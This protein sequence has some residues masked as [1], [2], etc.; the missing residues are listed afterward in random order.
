MTDHKKLLAL[1]KLYQ[2]IDEN[3]EIKT[4]IN[5]PVICVPRLQYY[6]PREIVLVG[7][8]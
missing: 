1:W 6:Q 5:A 8:S 3:G 2:S 4:V 7:E